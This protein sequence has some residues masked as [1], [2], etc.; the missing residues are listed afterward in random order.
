MPTHTPWR[1]PR[2]LVEMHSPPDLPMVDNGELVL[3][4]C[5]EQDYDAYYLARHQLVTDVGPFAARGRCHLLLQ[6]R[7]TPY[8]EGLAAIAQGDSIEVAHRAVQGVAA[9]REGN[10]EGG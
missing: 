4:W 10:G 5:R 2:F 6:P 1:L 7:G 8:P 9:S 3:G